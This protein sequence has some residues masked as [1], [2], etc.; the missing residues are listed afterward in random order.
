MTQNNGDRV[1]QARI[2]AHASWAQTEDRAARTANARKALLDKFERTV[3][4]D[5]LLSPEERAVRAE[6]A[7]KEHYLRLSRKS[8]QARRRRNFRNQHNGGDA[9]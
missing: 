8:A 1:L 6:H 5:G 4:P 3:G 7:R 9:A 2:A